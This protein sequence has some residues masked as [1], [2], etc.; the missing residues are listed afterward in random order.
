MTAKRARRTALMRKAGPYKVESLVD[1][2]LMV[3]PDWSAYPGKP[4][5][6]RETQ[7]DE[8]E[9]G[10]PGLFSR[11]GLANDVQDFLNGYKSEDR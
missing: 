3:S 8:N 4:G 9:A 2:T 6:R 1:G 7:D 10:G 11:L 5:W